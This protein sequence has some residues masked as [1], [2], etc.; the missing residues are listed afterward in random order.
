MIPGVINREECKFHTQSQFFRQLGVVLRMRL[1]IYVMTRRIMQLGCR[2]EALVTNF[3]CIGL[4]PLYLLQVLV[5]T[6]QRME[7]DNYLEVGDSLASMETEL[8]QKMRNIIMTCMSVFLA[9]TK[10]DIATHCGPLELV[11]SWSSV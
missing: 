7:L 4:V 11:T 1:D 8:E 9:T 3:L 5:W 2:I 10:I 6:K